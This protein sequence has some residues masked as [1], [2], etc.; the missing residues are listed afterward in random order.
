M[1]LKDL[2]WPAV[3]T[4]INTNSDEIFSYPKSSN[5]IETK[6]NKDLPKWKVGEHTIF[7]K[8]ANTA[9]KYAKRRGLW[10]EYYTIEKV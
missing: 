1:R 4:L 3:F 8:D 7:A 6:S 2:L 5:T 9:K 10:K